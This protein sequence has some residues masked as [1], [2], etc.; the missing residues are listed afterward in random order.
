LHTVPEVGIILHDI[1]PS[2][3]YFLEVFYGS[4]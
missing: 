1:G 3:D 4:S 2:L